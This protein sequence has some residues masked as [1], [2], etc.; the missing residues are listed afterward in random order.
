MKETRSCVACRKKNKKSE[1]IRIVKG[2]NN[3][4][5]YDRNQKESKRGLYFCKDLNC[6]KIAINNINKNK[7]NCKKIGIDA[8]SLKTLLERILVELGE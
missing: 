3:E 6:I 5:F 7:F 1:L 2:N 4:A 8:Q